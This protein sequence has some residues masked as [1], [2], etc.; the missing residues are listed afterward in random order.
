M[1]ILIFHG[2]LKDLFPEGKLSVEADSAA[3][4]IM[5]LE[6]RPGFQRSLGQV[7]QI[8][9]PDFQS[10]D[11]IYTKTD[12]TEVH[13][14]PALEGA[15][16]KPGMMQIL[17]GAALIMASGP[18]GAAMAGSTFGTAAAISANAAMAGAMMMLGGILQMIMPQPTISADSQP[19]S[20]Y[21]PANGNTVAIGTPIPLLIG[22]RR[23]Y[24]QI[25]SFNVDAKTQ[26]AVLAA[27]AAVV[28]QPAAWVDS[29][30]LYGGAGA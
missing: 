29:G 27:P 6:G 17:I 30:A 3:E 2:Y 26:G 12:K 28:E 11:S 20:N 18:I 25:L 9:L 8:T 16:G 21:L 13:V 24:G 7:H 15:G 1:M 5:A 14:V 10:A 4:A 23:A 22:R 19:R